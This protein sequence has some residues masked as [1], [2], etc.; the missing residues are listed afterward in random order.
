M[1][2]LQVE[3]CYCHYILEPTQ[4]T[5]GAFARHTKVSLQMFLRLVTIYSYIVQLLLVVHVVMSDIFGECL[6]LGMSQ[7]L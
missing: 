1:L 7:V 6:K 5:F 4:V 2:N 3:L